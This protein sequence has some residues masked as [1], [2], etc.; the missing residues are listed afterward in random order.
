METKNYKPKKKE[1]PPIV[2]L[3]VCETHQ[4]GPIQQKTVW[5]K[6]SIAVSNIYTEKH[7][8]CKKCGF[9]RRVL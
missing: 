2:E 1:H 6:D 3:P 8:T 5:K 4:F 9:V 7:M